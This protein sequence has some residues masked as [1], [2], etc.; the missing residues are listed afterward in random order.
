MHN[1]AIINNVVYGVEWYRFYFFHYWRIHK[2]E[3][4]T[5]SL[6][7]DRLTVYLPYDEAVTLINRLN[8]AWRY[9]HLQIDWKKKLL[10]SLYSTTIA[11]LF[12]S[13][14]DFSRVDEAMHNWDS[15]NSAI[16]MRLRHTLKLDYDCYC[17]VVVN[18]FVVVIFSHLLISRCS[19]ANVMYS[20]TGRS[21]RFRFTVVIISLF[22]VFVLFLFPFSLST[23]WFINSHVIA[24]KWLQCQS[25]SS[26]AGDWHR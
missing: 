19:K 13:I 10:L 22:D 2:W 6:Q 25:V 11:P 23:L 15:M 3:Q 17:F 16:T 7:S 4:T 1:F 12:P 5:R 18:L 9:C 14:H 20:D 24:W 8:S 26:S 21:W